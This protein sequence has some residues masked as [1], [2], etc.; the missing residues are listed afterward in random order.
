MQQ[1]RETTINRLADIIQIIHLGGK[2]GILT[3]ERECG[4]EKE[5]G[6]IQFTDGIVLRALTGQQ[7]GIL[8]FNYLRTWCKCRFSFQRLESGD[9]DGKE[10]DVASSMLPGNALFSRMFFTCTGYVP[11]GEGTPQLRENLPSQ[12]PMR[13]QAG[14]QAILDPEKGYLLRIQRR[15]L[16]LIDGARTKE[17]LACLMA[18]CLD[19]LQVLLDDLE[20]ANL[21]Q[22]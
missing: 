7:H 11:R 16:L 19:E 12:I 21:I 14:E 2:S 3:V 4:E 6:I 13:S 10:T 5:E 17:E 9:M 8:A 1:Q 15:L 20:K 18:R 22:Q